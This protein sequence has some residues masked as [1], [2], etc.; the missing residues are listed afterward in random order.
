MF[1]IRQVYDDLLPMNKDMIAQ[2]QTILRSQ[3]TRLFEEDILKL[4][5]QLGNPLKYRFR[6]LLFLAEDSKG[7]VNGFALLNHEPVLN[8]CY[9][10]FL[11]TD[12]QKMG[13]GI[14]EALL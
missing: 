9:L 12:K 1:R 10:D 3:F 6:T 2:V 11:S 13:G 8:F 4:P 5:D 14:R 7:H